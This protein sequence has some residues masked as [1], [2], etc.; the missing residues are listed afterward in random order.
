MNVTKSVDNKSI[1]LAAHDLFFIEWLTISY[2]GYYLIRAPEQSKAAPMNKIWINVS[3]INIIWSIASFVAFLLAKNAMLVECI[4]F[5]ATSL[6]I[7][8]GAV[9]ILYICH[10]N[11]LTIIESIRHAQAEQDPVGIKVDTVNNGEGN[12]SK[13]SDPALPLNKFKTAKKQID[14]TIIFGI[15]YIYIYI[16][17]KYILYSHIVTYLS[18]YSVPDIDYS[19]FGFNV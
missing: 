19:N 3:R 9:I 1:E 17:Y 8:I 12:N 13:P 4:F 5:I 6:Y 10:H 7:L 18:V 15:F 11:R 16:F 2:I 14:L